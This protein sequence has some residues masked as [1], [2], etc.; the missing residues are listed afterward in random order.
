MQAGVWNLVAGGVVV[1]EKWGCELSIP[2]PGW[3]H[4]PDP[5][6]A[7]RAVRRLEMARRGLTLVGVCAKQPNL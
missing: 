5:G 1:W 4:L 2:P 6:R 7:V 3:E